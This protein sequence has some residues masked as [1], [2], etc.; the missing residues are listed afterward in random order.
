[1]LGLY[2]YNAL[3]LDQ[4]A[5]ALWRDGEFVTNVKDGGKS[6][7][8]YTIYMYYVE[9]TMENNVITDIAPFRQGERLEKYLSQINIADLKV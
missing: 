9:V 3:N 4:R 1:M 8:L 5:D 6:F 7:A 2:E